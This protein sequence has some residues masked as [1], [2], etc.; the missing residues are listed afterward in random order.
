S[1]LTDVLAQTP[2]VPHESAPDGFTD[3]DAVEVRRHGEPPSFDF[4]PK[5]HAV[6][7]EQLGM[8]DTERAV[9]TSGSRLLFVVGE[10]VQ[11]Q[12]ARARRA[13]DVLTAHGFV[14]VIP[15]VLVREEAMFGSG[16][17]PT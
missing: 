14:P 9:R 13:L 5:D 16:F 8:L 11:V 7:G 6:L 12:S 4:E 2:N 17:L 10:S 3:E 15:P 1:E